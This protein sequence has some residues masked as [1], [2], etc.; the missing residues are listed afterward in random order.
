MNPA[1]KLAIKVVSLVRM[2]YQRETAVITSLMCESLEDQSNYRLPKSRYPMKFTPMAK[3]LQDDCSCKLFTIMQNFVGIRTVEKIEDNLKHQFVP[4]LSTLRQVKWG[5]LI[6]VA[7]QLNN[8]QFF[9]CR[10]WLFLVVSG[11]PFCTIR[12]CLSISISEN[13]TDRAWAFDILDRLW[14]KWV[15][16]A[17]FAYFYWS[18]KFL[19]PESFKNYYF[20]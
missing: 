9:I 13:W 11:N 2:Y 10:V 17:H 7:Q 8:I 1:N 20:R 14:M 19:E 15:L 3:T 6:Y 12:C 5:N 4:P 16:N 18:S